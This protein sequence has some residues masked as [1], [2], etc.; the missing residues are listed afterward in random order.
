LGR[1]EK[2]AEFDLAA[3]S[4]LRDGDRDSGF[5]DIQSNE[6]GTCS[7]GAAIAFGGRT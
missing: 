6:L 4:A 1:F 5:M 2:I 7:G 3:A